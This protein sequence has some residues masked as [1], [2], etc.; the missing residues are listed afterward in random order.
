MQY[1]PGTRSALSLSISKRQR[2]LLVRNVK[3]Y[4]QSGCGPEVHKLVSAMTFSSNMIQSSTNTR[5][6]SNIATPKVSN[7]V[8]ASLTMNFKTVVI[9]VYTSLTPRPALVDVTQSLVVFIQYLCNRSCNITSADD[10]SLQRTR[11]FLL[12]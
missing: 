5:W 11:K 2:A 4:R 8:R 7:V 9:A 3:N 10:A 1:I 6:W 12:R